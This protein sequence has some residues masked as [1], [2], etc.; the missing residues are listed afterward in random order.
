MKRTAEEVFKD[1]YEDPN[2]TKKEIKVNE[3][4]SKFLSEIEFK[5]LELHEQLQRALDDAGQ[6]FKH[7]QFH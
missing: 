5:K 2:E 7:D 1:E 3:T 6:Q 4:S